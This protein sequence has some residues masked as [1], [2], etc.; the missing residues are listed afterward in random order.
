MRL[1]ELEDATNKYLQKSNIAA[2]SSSLHLGYND[3]INETH[4]LKAKLQA[5]EE[6][7]K[8]LTEVVSA[9]R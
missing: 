1:I 6:Q 7:I 5:A 2:S 8:V 9:Q 4:K 3:N